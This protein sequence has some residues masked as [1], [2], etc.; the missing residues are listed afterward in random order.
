H[1]RNL[2]SFPTRRSSDLFQAALDAGTEVTEE[3]L[4]CIQQHVDRYRADDFFAGAT[5]RGA[6]LQFLK[7][8]PGLYARL[9]QMHDCGLLGRV[10]SEEH[11]SELQ[12]Q[13]NLV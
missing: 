6:L 5:D 7:P 8:R 2:L 10:R 1:H 11:T 4:S 9:S 13:S 3:A 12:S